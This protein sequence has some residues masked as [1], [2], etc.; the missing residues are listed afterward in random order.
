MQGREVLA[1]QNSFGLQQ[2]L[3]SSEGKGTGCVIQ[4]TRG[5][6]TVGNHCLEEMKLV[7]AAISK[8][9]PPQL[10]AKGTDSWKP[11]G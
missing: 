11:K 3:A 1:G 9:V 7:G 8:S 4:C 6:C 10:I 5:T 2:N